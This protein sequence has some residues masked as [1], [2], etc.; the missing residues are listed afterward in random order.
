MFKNYRVVSVTPAGRRQ[1]LEVLV[2]YLLRNKHLIDEHRFWLNTVNPKDIDYIYRVTKDHSLFKIVKPKTHP[3]GI[4]TI[5]TFFKDCVKEDTIYIRFDDDICYIAPDAVEKLLEFR[6][7]NRD[8]FLVY[9]HIIN[10]SMNRWETSPFAHIKGNWYDDKDHIIEKHRYFLENHKNLDLF[11]IKPFESTA[12]INI[13]CICWF[14][15][16]FKQFDGKVDK[17]EELWLAR[18]KP[19]QMQ[20]TNG[21]CGDSLVV[22]FAFRTQ[23]KHLDKTKLLQQYKELIRPILLV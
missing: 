12:I 21:I 3:Q 13:N 4:D 8:Y 7:A 6:L 20:R 10:N 22:H 16:E 14:G 2:P 11:K 18:L 19:R 23:R 5:C 17:Q 1:Y 9:P 15:S